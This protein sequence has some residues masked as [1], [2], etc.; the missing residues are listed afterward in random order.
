MRSAIAGVAL[1]AV[2]FIA[3]APAPNEPVEEPPR[4]HG[5]L[6]KIVGTE[7]DDVLRGTPGRDVIWG[8]GGDDTILGSLGND[9]LC[10]GPGL[11]LIHGGRGNDLAD[12]GAGD[13]D[14]VIGD[15]GDDKLLG[16][17]GDGDEVAGSLGIDTLSGGP[18]NFDLVHGDYGYDRMDGGPGQG[19]IASFATDVGA[20]RDGGVKASLAKHR[21]E[22]DGHD[23]LFRFESLEGSAFEDTLI[24]NGQGNTIDGGAGNDTIR[25]G[26]GPDHLLG[27]QGTDRCQGAKGHT[28]SC[29]KEAKLKAS[30]Y[31]EIDPVSGGG[32][33]L[34]LVGG[35]GHDAFV[36]AFNEKAST[37]GVTAKKGIA[38]GQGCS[39]VSARQASCA[40][41]GPARWVMADLGPGNDSLAVEGSLAGAQNVRLAGGLGNDAIHGGSEDDLIEAGYGADRLYGG[42][43]ADGLIGSRPGP[44]FLYGGPDGDLLAAGGGC[45][46]G[47]LVGGPGRDDASFAETPAHPGI[48][49]VSFPAH[50]AWIDAIKGCHKVHLSPTDEDMEGSFDWDILV[51]DGGANAMLGQPGR[52]RF[53]GGG[54]EDVIDARDGERDFSIQCGR[55]RVPAKKDQPV[56]GK[57]AGRALTDAFDPSPVLCAVAKHGKPVDGLG[58][59][60]KN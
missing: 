4:C 21:A 17:S 50:A 42:A 26:G 60:A 5:R 9:L 18:G 54:G 16:G 43:G 33:G 20:G 22:G 31:V 14:R 51:G 34:E 52:D 13:N 11:D 45:A 53:Y 41:E 1:A 6:A 19:D 8:G 2:V 3:A 23:R 57:P 12:G 27:G 38:V 56:R 40:T 47:A 30:A 24:G 48:L 58:N 39:R 59:A 35:G 7:G 25:G 44:T 32:G 36:L 49:H 55:G 15:L 46:G 10:G 28:F 29:G 37:F